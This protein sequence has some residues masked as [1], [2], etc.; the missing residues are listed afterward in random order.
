[1]IVIQPQTWLFPFVYSTCNIWEG[2]DLGYLFLRSSLPPNAAL[3]ERQPDK[4]WL[5]R[6]R[7]LLEAVMSIF[8]RCGKN[9][10]NYREI[11]DRFAYWTRLSCRNAL[12]QRRE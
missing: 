3:G 6:E 9:V 2:S 8:Q 11:G 5:T 1:M 4:C 7:E 10:A 12:L